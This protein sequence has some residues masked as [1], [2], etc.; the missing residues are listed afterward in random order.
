MSGKQNRK[1]LD[2][3]DDFRGRSLGSFETLW[4]RLR[5]AASL[6]TSDGRYSHAGM[7]RRHGADAAQAALANS[8]HDAFHEVLREPLPDQVMAKEEGDASAP[9][10]SLIPGTATGAE[11]LHFKWLY[12]AISALKKR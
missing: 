9:P 11:R 4:A 7:E 1:L 8:H 10:E 2:A 12:S 6:M 3:S 5:Y